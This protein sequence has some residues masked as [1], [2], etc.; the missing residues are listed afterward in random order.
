MKSPDFTESH[1][2]TL[3]RIAIQ[4]IGVH[5]EGGNNRGPRIVEYQKATWLEPG[6]WPWCAAFICWIVNKWQSTSHDLPKFE[7]PQTAGAFDMIRWAREQKLKVL[8][9]GEKVRKGDLVVFDFSHIGISVEDQTSESLFCVEGNTNNAGSRD[10][11]NGDG[12]H[13]KVR[14]QSLVR[15]LIRWEFV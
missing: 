5:E 12:V 11:L 8:N 3:V 4:E 7:R 13:R 9:E 1:I 6:A 14:H 15:N 2:E 10:S